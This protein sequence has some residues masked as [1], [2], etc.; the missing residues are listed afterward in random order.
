MQVAKRVALFG[1]VALFLIVYFSN[2]ATEASGP[3]AAA[4][5]TTFRLY[6]IHLSCG[7]NWLANYDGGLKKAIQ[8]AITQEGYR[9]QVFDSHT[10]N[11]DHREWPDRFNNKN[12]WL[13]YDIV[14]FKSCFPASHI[15]SKQMFK[16]FKKVYRK[17]LMKIFRSHP[18]I[19]FIIVTAPPL[20]PNETDQASADRARKF[21]NWLKKNFI[22]KYNRKNPDFNNVAVFDFFV[23]LANE[24]DPDK[25]MLKEDYRIDEWD[26]HPNPKGNKAATK[27]FI[28]FLKQVVDIWAENI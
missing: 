28:P 12:D 3:P 7:E 13:K 1:L 11:A 23:V 26:S 10:G 2:G 6:F 8:K 18:E 14:M 16:A 25:N 9:F 15:D 22:R 21:N 4:A 20:V 17:H 24:S 5:G 27:E 19:L